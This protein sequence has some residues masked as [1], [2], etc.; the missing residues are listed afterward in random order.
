V[1]VN[2][3]VKIPKSRR[4]KLERE[5]TGKTRRDP[6]RLTVGRR[7]IEPHAGRGDTA[8]FITRRPGDGEW[9]CMGFAEL[10][11]AVDASGRE[12]AHITWEEHA[13]VI[14][15]PARPI[16]KFVPA[17]K[18]TWDTVDAE[19]TADFVR[20]LEA[21]DALEAPDT[22][23]AFLTVQDAELAS[24]VTAGEG[25]HALIAQASVDAQ[26]TMYLPV[27]LIDESPTNPRE[28]D[29]DTDRL[30]ELSESIAALG[31]I[32]PVVVR[33][34]PGDP[35]RAELVAGHRRVRAARMAGL[36]HVPVRFVDVDD[37]EVLARQYTENDQRVG[38]TPLQEAR[39]L[40]A[41]LSRERT[42]IEDV[43]REIGRSTGYVRARVALLELIDEAAALLGAGLIGLGAAGELACLPADF[44]AELIGAGLC[45]GRHGVREG[46]PER[47]SNKQVQMLISSRSRR[48]EGVAWELT[49]EYAGCRACTGCPMRSGAQVSLLEG[50][51]GQDDRCLDAECFGTKHARAIDDHVAEILAENPA[52]VAFGAG[53]PGLDHTGWWREYR[54]VGDVVHGAPATSSSWGELVPGATRYVMGYAVHGGG[55]DHRVVI[56]QAEALGLLADTHPLVHA[57]LTGVENA[58]ALAARA[59]RERARARTREQIIEWTGELEADE[60]LTTLAALL[61]AHA[62]GDA[63]RRGEARDPASLLAWWLGSRLD[64][65]DRHFERELGLINSSCGHDFTVEDDDDD[66]GS[67]AI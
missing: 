65:A 51:G 38:I 15:E 39:A 24:E 6:G 40:G 5:L 42:S 50:P 58:A 54:R 3:I 9:V 7:A 18:L 67:M 20:V 30:A 41:M 52:W 11:L 47:W 59:A 13:G 55:V 4:D 49:G 8:W 1:H 43:A 17:G 48:L 33:P 66:Q 61:V 34:K 21:L 44:Q 25:S 22:P 27:G 64:P 12:S 10:V 16:S 19:V 53:R 14:P 45:Q 35:A 36:K 31:V 26:G 2:I 57:Q 56:Q 28:Q 63:T 62:G 60:A 46:Q 23:D 29:Y 37:D 32:Q